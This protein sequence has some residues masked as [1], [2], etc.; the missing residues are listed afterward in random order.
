MQRVLVEGVRVAGSASRRESVSS[1]DL[2][3]G[4]TL[5]KRG[6]SAQTIGRAELGFGRVS[7]TPVL[8]QI[9]ALGPLS[10]EPVCRGLADRGPPHAV[11]FRT[12]VTPCPSK[13]GRI[14]PTM[15]DPGDEQSADAPVLLRSVRGWGGEDQRRFARVVGIVCKGLLAQRGWAASLRNGGA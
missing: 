2:G 13:Y 11:P 14:R 7:V 12:G 4:T 10:A 5:R 1:G 8:A 6:G 9:R 3:A 15:G